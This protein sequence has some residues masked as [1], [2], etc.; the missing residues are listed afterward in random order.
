ME[1]TADPA[2]LAMGIVPVPVELVRDDGVDE[3]KTV[4]KTEYLG[5]RDRMV[6]PAA[7]DTYVGPSFGLNRGTSG[8]IL[9]DGGHQKIGDRSHHV[10]Y[11]RFPLDATPGT[12]VSARLRLYNAGNP[13]SDGGRIHVVADD[14]D[15]STLSYQGRPKSGKQVGDLKAVA[16]GEILEIPLTVELQGKKEL[17][18]VIEAD[19]CDGTDYLTR[20]SGKPAEL[21]IEYTE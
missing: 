5:D 15:S 3:A 6:V 21:R 16:S 7:E 12:I 14:W 2:K 17:R 19:N 18:L 1:L 13:T 11:L 4:L 10:A 20:E 9:V 8:S